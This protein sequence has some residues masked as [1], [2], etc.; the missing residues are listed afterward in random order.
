MPKIDFTITISILLAICALFA[1]SIT[2]VIT[3]HHQYKMRKLDLEYDM[4]IHYS[5]LI[6]RNKY[7]TYKTFLNMAGNYSLMNEYAGDYTK[8][9]AASQNVLLLCDD[10]SKPLLL[11]YI[12]T[13]NSHPFPA[14]NEYTLLLNKISSSFNRELSLL[15]MSSYNN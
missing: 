2:A 1:P 15:S 7:D 4:Q 8:I 5:D 6:Y 9:L 11:E 3:N 14:Q 10:L 12:D 13:L